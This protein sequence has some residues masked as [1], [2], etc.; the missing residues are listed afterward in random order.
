MAGRAEVTQSLVSLG[1]SLPVPAVFWSTDLAF[2]LRA[3]ATNSRNPFQSLPATLHFCHIWPLAN[4]N[5][6]KNILSRK[7]PDIIQLKTIYGG[8]AG[9]VCFCWPPRAP[10][11]VKMNVLLHSHADRRVLLGRPGEGGRHPGLHNDFTTL[12]LVIYL[13]C[14]DPGASGS[15]TWTSIPFCSFPW[16]RDAYFPATFPSKDLSHA[17]FSS[18]AHTSFV[19][20]LKKKFN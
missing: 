10:Q 16:K 17:Y 4:C 2:P 3:S 8:D 18:S 7:E 15:P 5:S 20:K 6:A 9:L 12:W 11:P 13:C 1:E 19:Q 14:R